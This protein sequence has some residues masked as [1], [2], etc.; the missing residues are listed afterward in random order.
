MRYTRHTTYLAAVFTLVQVGACAESEAPDGPVVTAP[1]G[2][3]VADP[4]DGEL[5]CGKACAQDAECGAGLHCGTAN[6]CSALC[7]PSGKQCEGTCTAQ[8]RCEGTLRPVGPATE[9]PSIIEPDPPPP[10]AD[11]CINVVSGFEKVVP[12]VM[13]LVDR[14]GSMD[15]K[16]FGG[17]S[18]RW[19]VVRSTLTD[20]TTGIVKRLDQDVRFG[21]M[22][23]T[24]VPS[25]GNSKVF[26]GPCPMLE[27]TPIALNNY[28]A[29][30]TKYTATELIPK[31]GGGHKGSTP[32]SES[33]HAATAALVA[34][35]EVGPK[36]LILATDGNP[37]NC[38][39]ADANEDGHPDQA[40]TKQMS[41]DA[42]KAAFTAGIKTYIIGVGPEASAA[43]LNDLAIAGQGGDT[44]ATP[45]SAMNSAQLEEAFGVII[46][47]ER[48]CSFPL[49]GDTPVPAFHAKTGT[50]TLGAQALVFEDP[51]GWAL[52][53]DPATKM[54]SV[55]LRGTACTTA[56]NSTENVNINFPCVLKSRIPK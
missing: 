13:L 45:F 18:T 27:T 21:L 2:S 35:T 11:E 43:H 19:E 29:L 3:A 25:Q 22:L 9:E 38:M 20:A 6:T 24:A 40:R 44:T 37:D 33:I 55:E 42:V 36:A 41:V 16:D 23:Y 26:E 32:T 34:Y 17:L 1:T 53:T 30:N 47:A 28:A 5:D 49:Q 48:S 15:A 10:P 31:S 8:G 7:T 4:C 54:Q 52:V 51:N 12:S 56:K 39:D 46:G 50:V 14:S